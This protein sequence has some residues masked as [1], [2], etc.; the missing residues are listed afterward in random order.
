[1]CGR[2]TNE[3]D[4]MYEQLATK[5]RR[6]TIQMSKESDAMD[7][8]S[9]VMDAKLA[10]IRLQNQVKLV[11]HSTSSNCNEMKCYFQ[12]ELQN[13]EKQIAKSRLSLAEVE[14]GL[15]VIGVDDSVLDH[16]QTEQKAAN[17]KGELT[18]Q[19]RRASS[20][21]GTPDSVWYQKDQ[22]VVEAS[23]VG[24]S[25]LS[26]RSQSFS[27]PAVKTPIVKRSTSTP[28]SVSDSSADGISPLTANTRYAVTPEGRKMGGGLLQTP[29]EEDEEDSDEDR[30]V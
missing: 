23:K 3:M 22:P 7:E 29:L 10:A 5:M 11:V 26:T 9:A 8:R 2:S 15:E 24:A 27:S 18:K 21:I 20:V 28:V 19:Y 6:G 1:M 16:L 14:L 12:E 30:W 17:F 13:V 4:R 25:T